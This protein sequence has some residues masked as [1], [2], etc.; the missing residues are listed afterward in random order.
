ME[1]LVHVNKRLKSRPK[2]QLPVEALMTQ[3]QDP[4]ATPFVTVIILYTDL[5]I[6]TLIKMISPEYFWM[7]CNMFLVFSIS[8]DWFLYHKCIFL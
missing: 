1:L 3:Y 7:D 6:L 5:C 8:V 2:V 4:Q